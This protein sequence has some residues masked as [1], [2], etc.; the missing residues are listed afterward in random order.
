MNEQRSTATGYARDA[1]APIRRVRSADGT[2]IALE[3]VTRGPAELVLLA[4]G[5]NLA[6]DGPEPPPCWMGSSPAG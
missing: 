3:Q 2:V 1:M 6:A 5:P 4:G